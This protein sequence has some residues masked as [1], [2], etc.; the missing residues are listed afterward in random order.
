MIPYDLMKMF[1]SYERLILGDVE[2]LVNLESPSHERLPLEVLKGLLIDRLRMLSADVQ[3]ERT[4]PQDGHILA[5][6]AGPEERCPALVLGHYDTV[7][8]CGTIDRMPFRI[9]NGRAFGPGIFD[10]KASLAMFLRVMELFKNVGLELPRPVWALIT[11]DEELGSPSSRGLIEAAGARVCL[12]F[13]AR[14][15]D[16]RRRSQ[17]VAKRGR[18]LPSRG[19]GQGGACR[20]GSR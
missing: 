13:G 12:C 20:S 19:R 1:R 2:E 16:G 11:A 17:D 9:A 14:A 6:F 18:S 4:P 7:W 10:M 3:T 8:P 5:R 15:G